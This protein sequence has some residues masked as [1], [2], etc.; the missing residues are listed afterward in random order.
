MASGKTLGKMRKFG[1]T[2]STAYY[3]EN[4][5][6]VYPSEAKT[7]ASEREKARP[8]RVKR[9]TKEE[10]LRKQF[11]KDWTKCQALDIDFNTYKDMMS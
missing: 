2:R 3:E 4:K 1:K 10:K 11:L 8:P 6:W 9:I 5:H 7:A